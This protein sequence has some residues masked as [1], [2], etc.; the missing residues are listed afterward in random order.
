MGL[1]FHD[2]VDVSVLQN[3]KMTQLF[4]VQTKQHTVI[5]LKQEHVRNKY[6][7]NYMAFP[8]GN[9]GFTLMKVLLIKA[10]QLRNN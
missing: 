8:R 9:G 10:N 3:R 5:V 2:I 6:T 4:Q 7:L 1:L